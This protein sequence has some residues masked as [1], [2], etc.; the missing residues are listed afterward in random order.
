MVNQLILARV[1]PVPPPRTPTPPRQAVTVS[2]PTSARPVV[3]APTPLAPRSRGPPPAL[4]RPTCLRC[5]KA[6]AKQPYHECG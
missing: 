5:S 4:T 2:A 6:I 1:S 3:V